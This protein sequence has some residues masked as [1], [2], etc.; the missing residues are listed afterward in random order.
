[1]SAEPACILLLDAA[2]TPRGQYLAVPPAPDHAA[3][4]AARRRLLA[5]LADPSRRARLPGPAAGPAPV[6][7]L[8]GRGPRRRHAGRRARR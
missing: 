2:G 4:E 5:A 1:M 7:G 8:P 6:P 3:D